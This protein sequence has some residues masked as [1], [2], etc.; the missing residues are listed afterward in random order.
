MAKVLVCDDSEFMR[1][2]IIEA[3]KK[4]GHEVI[5]QAGDGDEAVVK[6]KELRPDIVTMDILM[7]PDGVSAITGIRAFD[8]TARIVIVSILQGNQVEVIHGILAGAEGYVG[9]PVNP[10]IL[11]R[12]IKRV[13][14]VSDQD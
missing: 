10:N 5:G 12:E 3:L 11:G 13:L 14:S 9:K 4:N 8:T 7:K 6:Y 2:T 1:K